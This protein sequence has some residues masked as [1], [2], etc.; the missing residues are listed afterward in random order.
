[1]W[2]RNH[3]IITEPLQ[4]SWLLT[5]SEVKEGVVLQEEEDRGEEDEE[6]R[7]VEEGPL[8]IEEG[9]EPDAARPEEEDEGEPRGEGDAPD[10]VG[11]GA[12]GKRGERIMKRE[13]RVKE[14]QHRVVQGG[15]RRGSRRTR[16]EDSEGRQRISERVEKEGGRREGKM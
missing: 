4:P 16:Q 11:W 3:I 2:R 14:T 9:E 10:L 7:G 15:V 8:G 5:L 6:G 13:G 1:M 12:A